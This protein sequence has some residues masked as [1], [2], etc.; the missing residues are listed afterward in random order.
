VL[1]KD[2]PAAKIFSSVTVTQ[3]THRSNKDTKLLHLKFETFRLV[4]HY[5]V[6]KQ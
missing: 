2:M 5:V 1:E 3:V 6:V 4:R